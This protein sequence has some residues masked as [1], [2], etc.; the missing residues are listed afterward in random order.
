MEHVCPA[1]PILPGKTA[2]ARAFQQELDTTRKAD[3]ATS[4]KRS[5]VHREYWFLAE[6]PA[7]DQMIAYFA[8][9]DLNVAGGAFVQSQDPFDLWFKQ[10]LSDITG[11]D[12]VN[13]PHGMKLP[14]LVSIFES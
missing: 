7:G 4:D 6:L 9:D 13:L 2:Y 14:K 11:V 1:R 3:Y 12:F 10:C 8:P 5:K